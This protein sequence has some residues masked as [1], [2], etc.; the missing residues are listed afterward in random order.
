MKNQKGVSLIALIITI[1]VIIILAAIVMN[2]ST[3]TV[4]NAQYAKFAQEFGEYSDQVALK[5]ADV[6]AD[7]GIK[8]QIIN[9]AQNY[10]MTAQGMT[11]F[12]TSGDGVFDMTLPVGYVMPATIQKILGVSGDNVVAYVIDD[13]KIPNYTNAKQKNGDP[14]KEFYG[15]SNGQENHFITSDGQVFTIPGYPVEQDDGTIQYHIDTK[16]GHYYV[17]KGNSKLAVG[18]DK[19]VNGDTV[20]EADPIL[21]TQDFTTLHGLNSKNLDCTAQATTPASN[22]VK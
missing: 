18:T 13:S 1:I 22:K 20:A 4:G 11:T 12:G 6:K 2:S 10:Y 8:G 5:A 15:D 19:N 9:N 17:V 16:D 7:V 14:G 21:A 3:D